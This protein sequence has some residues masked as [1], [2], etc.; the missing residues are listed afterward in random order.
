MDEREVD[1]L[2]G[3]LLRDESPEAAVRAGCLDAEQIAAFVDGALLEEERRPIE[4]HA[5]RCE[6]CRT[7]LDAMQRSPVARRRGAPRVALWASLAAAAAILVALWLGDPF[8][9]RADS[10]FSV[11]GPALVLATRGDVRDGDRL[12][13]YGDEVSPG[14][15][16][17][18]ARGAA[19]T[20]L[21][22][23]RV[24]SRGPE[25]QVTEVDARVAWTGG[26]DR[27]GALDLLR[28][29]VRRGTE[30]GTP[31]RLISP[32]GAISEPKPTFRW[33][34]GGPS[35]SIL[36][37]VGSRTWP[38]GDVMGREL[39]YPS[40]LPPLQVGE[41][42]LWQ[43]DAGAETATATFRLI[44]PSETERLQSTLRRGIDAIRKTAVGAASDRGRS[45][46][47]IE[48]LRSA[49]RF[50]E[51]DAEAKAASERFPDERLVLEEWAFVRRDMGDD[52]FAKVLAER[53]AA[54]RR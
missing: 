32:I 41:S 26:A 47:M 23:D 6:R 3:H 8:G 38:R 13:A 14:A 5:N 19:V 9:W 4:E 11:S 49:E 44:E 46:F 40:E 28:N 51:A 31:L 54:C 20:F 2:L 12:L 22:P 39:P 35:P 16:L 18:L 10:A 30:A 27:R 25:P 48:L 43:V 53:A 7:A 52:S 45:V 24:V 33:E 34:G 1:R 50:E 42:N 15:R 29:S 37:R 17:R 21:L 36:V